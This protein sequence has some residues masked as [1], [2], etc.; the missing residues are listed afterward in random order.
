MIV[1]YFKSTDLH[2]VRLFWNQV[3]TWASVIFSNFASAALSAL[4]RYFCLWNLFSNSQTLFV[5]CQQQ[6]QQKIYFTQFLILFL[7]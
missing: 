4:A 5:I 3:L 2:L 7:N 6:Q 1:L